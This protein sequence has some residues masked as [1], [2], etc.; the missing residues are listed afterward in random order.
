MLAPLP[1]TPRSPQFL[2]RLGLPHLKQLHAAVGVMR[3]AML[4]VIA[5]RRADLAAGR[6][7]RDDLLQ[8]LLTV[9]AWLKGGRRYIWISTD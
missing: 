6:P 8:A 2:D 7:G 3:A 9:G 4:D 1:C 5:Q